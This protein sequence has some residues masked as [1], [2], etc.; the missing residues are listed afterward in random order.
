MVEAEEMVAVVGRPSLMKHL[1]VPCEWVTVHLDPTSDRLW[2]FDLSPNENQN[3][4][5]L[6]E[7]FSFSKT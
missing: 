7:C 1:M 6:I 2:N 3:C 5:S 4:V